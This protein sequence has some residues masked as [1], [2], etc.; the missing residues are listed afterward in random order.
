MSFSVPRPW[1]MAITSDHNLHFCD[2]FAPSMDQQRVIVGFNDEI[3][4]VKYLPHG[5]VAVATN[6]PQVRRCT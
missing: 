6:S 5:R 1:V 3:I 2:A 4:D